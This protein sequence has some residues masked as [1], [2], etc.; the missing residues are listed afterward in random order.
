[1]F[2]FSSAYSLGEI[3][4]TLGKVFNIIYLIVLISFIKSIFTIITIFFVRR[5]SSYFFFSLFFR[6]QSILSIG[7][8]IGY[9]NPSLFLNIIDKIFLIRFS[10]GRVISLTLNFLY[11]KFNIIF[12]FLRL[13][14]INS[15]F[16]KVFF[17]ISIITCAFLLIT[18]YIIF[19][20]V[21]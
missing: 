6:V 5:I 18:F 19:R 8:F 21:F 16:I 2:A 14:S 15:I 7:Y 4:I 3:I 20:N 12:I 9:I 13:A 11:L 1:M 10:S 17:H